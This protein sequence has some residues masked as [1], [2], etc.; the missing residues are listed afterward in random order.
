[1]ESMNSNFTFKIIWYIAANRRFLVLDY[2]RI[3]KGKKLVNNKDFI[4]TYFILCFQSLQEY[5][6]YGKILYAQCTLYLPSGRTR[7]I[8]QLKQCLR[9]I[10][11]IFQAIITNELILYRYFIFGGINPLICDE[12]VASNSFILS[13]K[14]IFENIV[15]EKNEVLLFL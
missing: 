15:P 7:N 10:L 2:Q 3:S 1:M 9:K 6:S 14:I 13:A 5:K 12:K 4:L 11:P 8:S